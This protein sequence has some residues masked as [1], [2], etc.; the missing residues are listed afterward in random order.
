MVIEQQTDLRPVGD[1][2]PPPRRF[3]WL[4]RFSKDGS[5]MVG[6]ALVLIL[7]C[8][9]I[10]APT[11]ATHDPLAVD[12]GNTMAGPSLSHLLGTDD[13]GRDIFSRLVYGARISIGTA[14]LAG[15]LVLILGLGF[16]V[17]SGLGPRWC[18]RLIMRTVDG[19]LAFPN[20]ILA[21]V[22]AGVIGGGIVGVLLALVAVWW[23]MYARIVRGIVLQVREY[24]FIDA[25]H[26]VGASYL[27]IAYRHILPN[28]L[29]PVIVLMTLGMGG[30]IL[31]ISALSF[32]GIGVQPPTPE[33]G[34]MINSG[35][36]FLSTA[37]QLMLLPGSCIFGAVL[38][39]NLMGDGLRDALDPR[40][41]YANRR[42]RRENEGVAR[43]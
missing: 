38:G 19:L 21:L 17:L 6:A 20:L 22:I 31:A 3:R 36:R 42:A 39:F 24:T 23:A 35:R 11:I 16:G 33:W 30:I 9:A 1:V 5:A 25:A 12:P 4:R 32:L 2:I 26:A 7:S 37:P 41:P 34:S 14:I 29:P 40:R 18:D 8:A 43:A 28:V 10:L 27:Q 15:A 13:V